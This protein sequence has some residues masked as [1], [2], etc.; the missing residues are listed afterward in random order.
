MTEQ[1]I[2]Q[3]IANVIT[4][5]NAIAK[6]RTNQQQGFKYR[7]VDDVMNELHGTFAE[8]G[9]FVVPKVTKEERGSYTTKNGALWNTSRLTIDFTFFAVDGSNV[10]ATVIGEGN[11]SGDK[12]SNKA[13]SIAF[14]YAC[15]QV[16]CIPTEDDK[17]PDASKPEQSNTRTQAQK[18]QA[19]KP[20]PQTQKPT[21]AQKPAATQKPAGN[22]D[23]YVV[24][25][26]NMHG[27]K[28]PDG[29]PIFP[30][31]ESWKPF[32]KM[33]KTCS[34]QD[35]VASCKQTIRGAIEE[36]NK[37]QNAP[38]SAPSSATQEDIF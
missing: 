3:A 19:Q 25:M 8:C 20:A 31:A 34:M 21:T 35:V 36:Y 11:D 23:P 29:T 12:A 26:Q 32:Q 9:I 6:D 2:Y 30:T 24:E 5:T 28:L 10:T 4:K 18:P 15:I 38:A 27:A 37:C 33:A 7:G 17:D 14:K 1:K 22:A 16:F 13:L